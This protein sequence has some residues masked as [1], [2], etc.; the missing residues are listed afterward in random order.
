MAH[1]AELA[2]RVRTAL[3]G[4]DVRE[5]RMFGGLAFMVD[6]KMV[7]CVS[8]GGGALLVRVSRSRDAEYLGVPGARRAEMGRGRSM[9]EGWIAVDDEAL[10]GDHDLQ[11]W[12]DAVLAHHAEQAAGR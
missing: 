3:S 10:A 6:E 1:D 9:G 5:V 7:A 12:V 8:G 2:E 11:F 4:R